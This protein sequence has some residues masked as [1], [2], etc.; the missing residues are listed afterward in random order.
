MGMWEGGGLQSMR[1]IQELQQSE[2]A[3][4]RRKNSS[5]IILFEST[6]ASSMEKTIS[7]FLNSSIT[8]CVQKSLQDAAIDWGQSINY[9]KISLQQ[10]ILMQIPSA[11]WCLSVNSGWLKSC[12]KQRHF[13]FFLGWALERC[14]HHT[15][16][17]KIQICFYSSCCLACISPDETVVL[18]RVHPK[19]T[20]GWAREQT[21]RKTNICHQ[22]YESK[23][24]A[25]AEQTPAILITVVCWIGKYMKTA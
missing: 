23:Q 9:C 24:Q 12:E 19:R 15:F 2:N 5:R 16:L 25:S 3:T 21:K 1:L 4:K 17:Q 10:V 7:T 14:W 18:L 11:F 8:T 13:F 6:A 20:T 22:E